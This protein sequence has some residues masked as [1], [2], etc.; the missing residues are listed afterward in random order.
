MTKTR[1]APACLCLSNKPCCSTFLLLNSTNDRFIHKCTVTVQ[2]SKFMP[3]FVLNGSHVQRKVIQGHVR[4]PFTRQREHSH[5]WYDVHVLIS[6]FTKSKKMPNA[7]RVPPLFSGQIRN[8]WQEMSW[9]KF[10]TCFITVKLCRLDCVTLCDS[11]FFLFLLQNPVCKANFPIGPIKE[12]WICRAERG[13]Q[14]SHEGPFHNPPDLVLN[15]IER[16]CRFF[17]FFDH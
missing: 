14:Q 17:F 7:P 3:V 5:W 4:N 9:F 2:N 6:R 11:I 1:L 8:V 16:N 13:R 15:R 10:T 12:A